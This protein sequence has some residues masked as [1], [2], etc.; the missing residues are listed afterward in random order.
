MPEF[1][2]FQEWVVQLFGMINDFLVGIAAVIG[3]FGIW[4]W[5]REMVGKNKYELARKIVLLSLRS[6]LKSQSWAKR[7]SIKRIMTIYT[8]ASLEEVA[9]S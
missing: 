8:I 9:P 2:P 3:V 1:R 4:Q 5:R 6:C 7:R